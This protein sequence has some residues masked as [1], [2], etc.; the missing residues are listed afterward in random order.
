[1]L[2][3]S[4]GL[5]LFNHTPVRCRHL[6]LAGGK[7]ETQGIVNLHRGYACKGRNGHWNLASRWSWQVRRTCRNLGTALGLAPETHS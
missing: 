1:M 3:V 6:C 5:G 7:T 4:A 2:N